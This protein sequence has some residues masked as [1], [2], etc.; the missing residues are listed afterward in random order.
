LLALTEAGLLVGVKEPF[1]GHLENLRPLPRSGAVIVVDVVLSPILI[2]QHLPTGNEG[3]L[4]A[5]CRSSVGRGD[6]WGCGGF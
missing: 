4:G 6:R 5:L 2:I 3:L 1:V